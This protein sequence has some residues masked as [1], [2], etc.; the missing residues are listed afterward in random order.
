M[1]VLDTREISFHCLLKL[2]AR[3]EKYVRAREQ[4]V[5][6]VVENTLN[7]NTHQLRAKF[8]CS[9]YVNALNRELRK[10]RCKAQAIRGACQK[11]RDHQCD[12]C[13]QSHAAAA[14]SGALLGLGK[15]KGA[16]P[17]GIAAG[18]TLPQI[19]YPSR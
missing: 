18:L 4:R 16:Q 17:A 12:K 2:C 15:N 5:C 7:V 19:N 9:S 6:P 11:S 14:Q 1:N 13:A 3:I 10:I 8:F